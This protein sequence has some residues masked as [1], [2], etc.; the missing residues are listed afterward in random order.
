M[1]KKNNNDTTIN[2]FLPFVIPNLG[3]VAR[4]SDGGETT[5]GEQRETKRDKE[6][7]QKTR[8]SGG[9]CLCLSAVVFVV[10]VSS[11]K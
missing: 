8:G 11:V 3:P 4:N 6:K 5:D 9:T 7:G 2:D 10:V 1:L